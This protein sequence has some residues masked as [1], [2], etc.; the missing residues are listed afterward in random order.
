[1]PDFDSLASPENTRSTAMTAYSAP[2]GTCG[3]RSVNVLRWQPGA[4]HF[5]RHLT[6]QTATGS[7]PRRTSRGRVSTVS[8][9]RSETDPQSGHAAAAG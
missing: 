2:T 1:M 4:S 6:H 9:R 8:C 5:Q 7:P 3:T